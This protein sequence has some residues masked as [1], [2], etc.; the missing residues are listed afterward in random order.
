MTRTFF[1]LDEADEYEAAADLLTRRC[2]AWADERGLPAEP[3]VLAAALESRHRSRDGRLAYWDPEQVR[4]FLLEWVP[5]FVV[6]P[7][8]V[9][10]AAPE[11][12]LTT[13]FTR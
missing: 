9:L 13:T 12:L 10:D 6:A 11:S 1:E 7:R 8:D 2:L 5:H 4:R 3:T